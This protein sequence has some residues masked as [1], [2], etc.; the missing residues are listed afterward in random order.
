M[1]NYV[2]EA[3]NITKKF[4]GV[5][6]NENVSLYVR[7]GEI[8]GL[9]GENGAGKSTLLGILNGVYPYDTY[10]GILKIEGVEVSFKSTL[11]TIKYGIGFV[12][13]EI[14]VFK[15]FSVAENIFMSDL[16][17]G[18]RKR[19]INYKDIFKAAKTLLQDNNI[20]LQ[21][22]EDVRKLSV[23]KQQMLMI[24][25]ALARNPKILILDEPTTSLSDNDVR[26]LFQVIRELKDKGKSVIFV[27]HKLAEILELTD[28]LTIL[29]D[30]KNA[31]EFSSKEYES[32]KI[33]QGMIGREIN[34]MYPQRNANI[35]AEVLKVENLTIEH[36]FI[37]GRNR[38]EDVSFSVREG[39]VIGLAGLV[40]SGRTETV[41]SIFGLQKMKKGKIFLH[42]KEVTLRSTENSI[43][44]GL[45]M[46]TED[47]KKYGLIFIW[48]ILKNIT[49]SDLT[50]VS[51]LKILLS[52]KK[53][54]KV[55][56]EHILKLNI[57]AI[58]SNTNVATLSGGN[59]QKVVLARSL[60]VKP[61]VVI[62]DEPT[63]GIDVGSK[64][65][66]YLL[67]N[68][69]AESGV[70]VIMISSE[71][72]ELM[73]LCDRF[74]V[75]AEGKITEELNKSEAT[76]MKIMNAAVKTFKMN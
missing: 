15:S 3:I 21:P 20:D 41:A 22:D 39:E 57:K 54:K 30:G 13:Q 59:Q 2:L 31:G 62:F 17:L 14:N 26:K 36:E 67:I 8:L 45:A 76:E 40:G 65:E 34:N 64:N 48:D 6:A 9:I 38:V 51:Y 16:L 61:K 55:A 46:V 19:I 47:R 4:P 52:N 49:V 68:K 74:V 29:R 43:K 56:N 37:E 44:N 71:L 24:A 5:I 7:A 35:G 72:P 75:L 42:G 18:K 70:A 28:R 58:S 50:S 11:D 25:R 12:P 53:E 1:A 32:S 63:K 27:T 33:I 73:A 10:T 69:L 23:G 60:N 66:I